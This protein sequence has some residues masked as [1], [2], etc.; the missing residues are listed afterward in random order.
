MIAVTLF[1]VICFL[2]TVVLVYLTWYDEVALIR[3]LVKVNN[4]QA[5]AY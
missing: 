1:C 3:V 2:L 5:V 4:R